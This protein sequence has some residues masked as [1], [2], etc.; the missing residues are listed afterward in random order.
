[1]GPSSHPPPF[2]PGPP[3][4]P[5]HHERVIQHRD[6]STIYTGGGLRC[7]RTDG[8]DWRCKREALPEQKYCEKHQHR[9]QHRSRK[10]RRRGEEERDLEAERLFGGWNCGRKKLQLWPGLC[11]A[12]PDVVRTCSLFLAYLMSMEK[13]ANAKRPLD[14]GGPFIVYL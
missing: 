5:Q 2:S 13:S 14:R 8:K 10:R 9:G 7:L 6:R 4:E 3:S 11:P 12:P 1:V